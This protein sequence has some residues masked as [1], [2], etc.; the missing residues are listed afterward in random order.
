M[1]RRYFEVE[2]PAIVLISRYLISKFQRMIL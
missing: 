1:Q 2:Q